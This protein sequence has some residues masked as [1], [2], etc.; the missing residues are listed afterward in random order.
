MEREGGVEGERRWRERD[1]D[2]EA[3]ESVEND[4]AVEG[5]GV[6]ENEGGWG[7]GEEE[8]VEEEKGEEEKGE[9]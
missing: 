5:W 3:D 2:G 6:R 4:Q 7:E 1:R 8:E 9:G